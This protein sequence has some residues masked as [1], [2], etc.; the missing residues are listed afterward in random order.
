M[1]KSFL[2]RFTQSSSA[3]RPRT[4][5]NR[6]VLS[7]ERLDKRAVLAA[8]IG[9]IT[10][11]VFID[12]NNN[13]LDAGDT[14]LAGVDVRLFRDGGN[15]VFGGDDTLVGTDTSD[16][17]ASATPGA[18]TF[19]NLAPGLYFI[20]QDDA[21]VPAGLTNPNPTAVTIATGSVR[22]RAIDSYDQTNVPTLLANTATAVTSTLAAPE[23]IGG[24]RDITLQRTSGAGSL[25]LDVLIGPPSVLAIG[26]SGPPGVATIQ[27]DGVDNSTT[28]SPTGLGGLDL[29]GSDNRS[30]LI[31]EIESAVPAVGGSVA[32]TIYSSA[33]AFSTVTI[34]Y[35]AAANPGPTSLFVPFSSF[36][37]GVG[38]A[39]PAD[40]TSVGAI[41]QVVTLVDDQDVRLS[42][43]ESVRPE[44]QTVNVANIQ[45]LTIGNLVFQDLNADGVFNTGDVGIAGVDVELYRVAAANSI[46]NPATDTLV[47]TQTTDANGAYS[48]PNNI[49]PGF[50]VAVIPAREFD[51]TNNAAGARTL[52]GFTTSTPTPE[53]PGADANIDN[54][55]DGR[56]VAGQMYIATGVFTLISGTEPSNGGNTNNT[57]D[58][59]FVSNADLGITKTFVSLDTANNGTRTATFEIS[60]VN[61]GP[62]TATGVQVEDVIPAG[63]T[64]LGVTSPTPANAVTTSAASA[65][66]RTFDLIDIPSSSAV[67]FR[68]QFTVNAGVFDDQTNTVNVT[69][70]QNDPALVNNPATPTVI[71]RNT[72]SALLD[73]PQNDLTIAKRLETTTGTEITNPASVN[74]GDTVVYRLTVNNAPA[75]TNAVNDVAT[76]VTVV[77]TLPAGVTFVSGTVNGGAPGVGIT[78]DATTRTVTANVGTVTR[79][80]PAIVLLNVRVNPD[81]GTPI[82]NAATVSN[83]PDTDNNTLNDTANISNI[84]SRAVDLTIDKA[85]STATGDN[86][87]AVF[88][89]PLTFV[90]TVTNKTTS[91]GNARGF[92]V[93]DVLPAGLTFV[94]GSFDAGTSG[95]T[96]AN[97]GQTLTFTGGALAVGA[98]A[99]FTFDALI[100]QNAAASI[101]NVA[102]VAAINDVA[103][104]I[105]DTDINVLNGD[106]DDD[107]IIAAAR[108]VNLTV[109]KASNFSGTQTPVVGGLTT[110]TLSAT[111]G[112][113][114]TYSIRVVN[115]GPSDAVNV[116]VRDTLPTGVT[117]TSITIGANQIVD[118]NPDLGIIDFVIPSVPTGAANAVTV[119]VV[120][121]I[122]ANATG[123]IVNAV[124]ISGGGLNDPV[125]GNA[126]SVSTPLTP[127]INLVLDKTG[128]AT[129]IPGGPDIQYTITV[130]NTGPSAVT[131]A[132]FADDL[133]S[134]V[135]FRSATLNGTPV[136]NTGTGGDVAFVIPTLG[137]NSATPATIVITVGVNPDATTNLTNSA[138]VSALGEQATDTFV[139]TLN[140]SA[141]IT[142][143][144]S[145]NTPTAAPGALLIYSIQV[146]NAGV[147]TAA[148]VT[149]TD[150]LP[151]GLTFESGTGPNG[152]LTATGQTVTVNVG[153]LAPNATANFTINARVATT[154][155]GQIQNPASVTTT[156]PET[157]TNPLPNTANATTTIETPDPNTASISGRVFLDTD[158]DGRFDAT[159]RGIGGVTIRLRNTGNATVLRTVTTNQDGTYAFTG[160]AAGSYEVEQVQPQG[161]R[162]GLE[163]AGT[164]ATPAELANGIFPGIVLARGQAAPD[165]NYAEI[166]LLSKR[167]FLASST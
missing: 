152:A 109:S 137:A 31:F 75:V 15:G 22:V 97:N 16:A 143:T 128:P 86:S 58:F 105:I 138:T 44:V 82:A 87:T 23:A 159:E 96:L 108:N 62:V 135:T 121:Q 160:L 119:Q 74:T 18:Y 93:T 40:F 165:F 153:T 63:L 129:A 149:L 4:R 141:D 78:F 70:D 98:S 48:F 167:R 34:N 157:T 49:P 45:P 68:V 94:A 81:A 107:H 92:T 115:D 122:A 14:R 106:N 73:L 54:D 7:L 79:G 50:Y 84:V 41:E 112:G 20:D 166:E 150:V 88:G 101:T 6:R 24:E 69:A 57:I 123:P 116:N 132:N 72:H 155:T 154:F 125:A 17:L 163:Q 136:T 32:L 151:T 1:F 25:T 67:S 120:G 55:D 36:T 27:Y 131:N 76:G 33:T 133:P 130:S 110:D 118:N 30:G 139:T 126:A 42:L 5:S 117:A 37:T 21:D 158:R 104:N 95:V 56:A 10:G 145:V 134:G 90:I 89:A 144:K 85:V 65:N 91:P 161:V 43:V 114:I 9:V 162:D 3:R 29:D 100:A 13:G 102:S 164:N 46:V 61:N 26:S 140:P 12:I 51:P 99:S 52:V 53:T 113:L 2:Q 66:G 38:A 146:R 127:D 59:G 124:T 64:F 83:S 77:D 111:P 148:G 71:S 47:G 11:T 8:D 80:T 60:V 156:T 35:P 103:N 19:E 147:S 142:V 39:N 28:L